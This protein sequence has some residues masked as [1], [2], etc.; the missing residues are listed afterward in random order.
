MLIN[1]K[2]INNNEFSVIVKKKMVT[3]HTV[4]ISDQ[5]LHKLT[6]NL[7][8]KEELLKFSFEFLLEKEDNTSILETFEL[9]E[10]LKYFPDF[11]SHI[12]QWIK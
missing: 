7:K 8:T 9:L 10:I 12:E 6:K 4:I 11:S 2:Q 1:I 5:T 3:E